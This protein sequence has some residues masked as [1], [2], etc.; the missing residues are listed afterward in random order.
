VS[1]DDIAEDLQ[2]AFAKVLKELQVMFPPPDKAPGHEDREVVVTA[3]LEK[4]GAALVMVCAQYGMDE[5]RVRVHWDGTLRPAI[6]TTVVLIGDLVEQH[7]D[8]LTYVLFTGAVMLIPDYWLLRPVFGIFGF[9][10]TGPVKGTTVAWA[11][12]VF[13]GAAVSKGSWF[14]FLDSVAISIKAP[15]W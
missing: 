10:P 3:A 6:H 11:Q 9:G 14:A 12:R 1:L 4:A 8:L 2:H 13:Y 5:E 15:G 7:P